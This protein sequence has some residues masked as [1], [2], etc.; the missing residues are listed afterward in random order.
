MV[1]LAQFPLKKTGL[2]LAFFLSLSNKNRGKAFAVLSKKNYFGTHGVLHSSLIQWNLNTLSHIHV[3]A[4][5]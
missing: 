3:K 5:A 4:L 1:F 2:A